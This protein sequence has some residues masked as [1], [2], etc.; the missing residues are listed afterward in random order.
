LP[1]VASAPP[2]RAE[3]VGRSLISRYAESQRHYHDG[4]HLAE[5]LDAV[6]LLAEHADDP[7]AVR[8][9]AWFHDAVYEPTAGPGANEEASARLAEDVLTGLGRPAAEVKAVAALVRGTEHH[10]PSPAAASAGDTAVLFDADLAIL[11][12]SPG[13]YAEYAA[14]VR[15]EYAHV[16]ETSFRSGRAAILRG[17]ADRPRIYLTP[18]AYTRW[19][20]AARTNL[21]AEL[22]H[23]SDPAD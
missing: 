12:S 10:E 22:A 5:V 21:A 6:D 8:L 15:A 11:G 20:S 18:T 9:A 19:E 2:E 4:R 7:D 14:D 1:L 23:L 16:P 17:F 13:R 3:S